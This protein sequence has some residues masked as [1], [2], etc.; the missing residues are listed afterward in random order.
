MSPN[1]FGRP[2][3]AFRVE[4]RTLLTALQCTGQPPP[5]VKSDL[6]PGD[7]TSTSLVKGSAQTQTQNNLCG[8][9]GFQRREWEENHPAS[10]PVGIQK[11]E[12]AKECH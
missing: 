2:R 1:I 3:L 4:V 11:E 9:L 12:S 6:G 5:P 10:F 8:S 7:I